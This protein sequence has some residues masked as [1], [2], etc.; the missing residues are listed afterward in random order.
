MNLN[1][2]DTE[3]ISYFQYQLIGNNGHEGLTRSQGNSASNLPL[4]TY[5][6]P[7]L[8]PPVR[9]PAHPQEIVRPAQELEHQGVVSGKVNGSPC[10]L[11]QGPEYPP[12]SK[13]FLRD[14]VL[15]P[16]LPVLR[17]DLETIVKGQ[18]NHRLQGAVKT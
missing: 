8:V 12:L 9:S 4:G 13:D 17:S 11:S 10:F 3:V 1:R 18:R 16:E 6:V 7:N 2:L 14:G 15:K 5:D